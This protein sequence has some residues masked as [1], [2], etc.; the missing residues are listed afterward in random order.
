[1]SQSNT[2]TSVRK[3]PRSLRKANTVYKVLMGLL[4]G[5]NIMLL[6]LNNSDQIEIPH[7]YFEVI[8][9]LATSFPIIWSK[10]LDELKEYHTD[11]TPEA[12]VDELQAPDSPA[13]TKSNPV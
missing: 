3:L 4:T 13:S 5:V 9:V 8:S 6:A 7:I 2:I 12:S 10:I 11:L 1:M